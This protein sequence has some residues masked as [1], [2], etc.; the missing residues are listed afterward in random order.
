MVKSSKIYKIRPFEYEDNINVRRTLIW[1]SGGGVDG[2]RSTNCRPMVVQK[3]RPLL[4]LKGPNFFSF[5]NVKQFRCRESENV[6]SVPN[7][8]EERLAL[9]LEM[10]KISNFSSFLERFSEEH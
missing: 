7:R 1:R 10:C 5:S 6:G 2:F 3:S 4:S 8:V 9:K